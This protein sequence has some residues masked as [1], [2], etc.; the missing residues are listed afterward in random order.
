MKLYGHRPTTEVKG[1]LFP[2]ERD[3]ASAVSSKDNADEVGKAKE[4]LSRS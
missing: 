4:G 3:P 2:I 1:K